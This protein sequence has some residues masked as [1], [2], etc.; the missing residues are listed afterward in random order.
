VVTVLL[1][2]LPIKAANTSVMHNNDEVTGELLYLHNH[3]SL[4]L[5]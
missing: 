4:T 2:L 5:R 3:K 1:S